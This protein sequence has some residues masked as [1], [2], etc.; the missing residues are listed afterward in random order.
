M[1]KIKI[2]SLGIFDE[3]RF[4][5]I[6]SLREEFLDS[7][8]NMVIN[9]NY[10][11]NNLA[12][13]LR[14]SCVLVKV[15]KVLKENKNC[16]TIILKSVDGKCLP[17]FRAGQKIALTFSID[18]NFYTLPFSLASSPSRSLDGE[19]YITICKDS[20]DFLVDYLFSKVKIGE[21][22]TVSSPFGDFYYEPLRDEKKIIAVVNDMGI[23]PVY[24]MIQAIIDGTEDYSLT[25]FYSAKTFE[26]LLFSDE[27]ME[28]ADK[29]NKVKVHFVLSD[30]QKEGCLTGFV[31][32]DK[33]R[34]EYDEGNTSFFIA[35]NEGLL[36]YMDKELER[37]KLPKK[38]VRYDNFL[39]KCNIKRVVK[40]NLT[41]SINNEKF[42]I[43]CYNNKTIMKAILDSGIYIPSKCQNGSCGFCRS[44]LVLGEV[45]VVNDKRTAADKKFN[46]IHPCSTYP[47]SD[48]EIIVR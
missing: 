45:K 36:K 17:P 30:E 24:S 20:D 13:D 19:Y 4:K 6:A 48:L 7:G 35:G 44:E 42:N 9:P 31:S 8:Y 46:Y 32:S 43:P 40:Y 1:D 34:K 3:Q 37:F 23:V 2:S 22:F 11:V 21:K 39:P 15:G 18:G 14:P 38:F 29:S 10:K 12:N 25:L 26:E 5:K 16:K 27:L 28:Y 33:I 41:V 47:L